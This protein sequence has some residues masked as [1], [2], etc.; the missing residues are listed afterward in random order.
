MTDQ[1]LKYLEGDLSSISNQENFSKI[2]EILSSH[3]DSTCQKVILFGTGAYCPIHIGHLQSYDIAAKFLK[4]EFDFEVIAGYIS[5]SCDRYLSYKF[6]KH[7]IPQKPIS[8]YHR[9]QMIRLACEDHNKQPDVIP[10]FPSGWEGLQPRTVSHRLVTDHFR[11]ALKE[12]FP[13]ED[14]FVL[15]IAG[16]DL[17]CRCK[18]S[19]WS[20]CVVIDRLDTEYS[21]AEYSTNLD[22]KV[23]ICHDPKYSQF[24]SNASSTQIRR[25][26]E[27]NKSIDGL[28]YS[29]VVEYI[30]TNHLQ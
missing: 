24:F 18:I 14:I 25:L 21:I 7:S 2:E 19:G 15:Y 17:F 11:H 16:A 4:E 5:P 20:S 13:N 8:F 23:Y 9:Y 26:L 27:E 29:S 30:L 3:K 1:G 10:I 6:H 22:K 12:K 28:T